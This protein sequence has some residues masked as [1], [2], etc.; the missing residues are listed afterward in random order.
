MPNTD[1]ADLP[2][3]IDLQ[4]NG[5]AGLDVNADDVDAGTIAALTRAQWSQ[6]VTTFLPTVITAAED[7]IIRALR[8]IAEARE[9]D[10]MI[11]HSIAGVHVEGPALNADDG[12]RGAHDVRHLRPPD[13]A[14]L[15]RWQDASDGL[16]RI[17]T[18]APERP[19]ALEFISGAAE[20]GVLTSLGHCAPT[21]E[22]V[23]A[24][25]R[26]GAT[27]STH[28]GNGTHAVLPRHPNH[29]WAQLAVDAL[30]AMF[31]TD[32]HHL[33]ADTLTAMI[34][35]K[36]PERCVLTS[37]SAALAG[38]APGT[39]TTPVGGDVTVGP[40]GRLTLSGTELLAGSGRSLLACL[41][42]AWAHLPFDPEV[43][44]AMATSNPARVLG[45]DERV[46]DGGDVVT[47]AREQ[48]T[49]RVTSTRIQGR[50]VYSA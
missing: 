11:A 35:A 13:L 46:T 32:G 24:A 33:P 7:K 43:T 40:D 44:L 47:C 19:A 18:L 45:L 25:V 14:E 8:A 30:T 3:L 23:H 50:E 27:L 49:S 39:Y 21:S 12:P 15:D 42:W 9:N 37:D 5:Y 10:A 48:G 28:L 38:S 36:S 29:I 1:D 2:G 6:G 34:R 4:V 17:V 31:I 16:V 26:A 22:Q 20:R 41:D